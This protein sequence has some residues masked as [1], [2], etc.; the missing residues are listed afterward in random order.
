MPAPFGPITPTIP[1]GRE[2]EGEVLDEKPVA[3]ALLHVLGAHDDVAEARAGRDVDLDRVEPFR[4]LLGEELLV[5]GESRLRLG[6]ARRRAHPHPLELALERPPPGGVPLLLDCQPRFLLLEPRGVV[7]LERE[8]LPAVELEDPAGHVVEEVPIVGHGDHGALVRLEVPLEPRNGLGVEVVRGLV[9]E[10]QVGRGEQEPTE[11]DAAALA[12]GERRHVAVALREPQRVHR[13]VEV[14]LEAPGVGA[15]DAVLHLRLLGQERVEVGVGLGERGG[16]RV[17]AVEQVAQLADAVLDVAAHVLRLVEV[18]LLL[19]E[20]HRRLRIELGDPGRRLLEPRHDPEERRLPRAVRPEHA[21]LRSVQ[22]R[23]RDVREHLPLGAVELVGPVHGVD[24]VGA[25]RRATVA[26]RPGYCDARGTWPR[27]GGHGDPAALAGLAREEPDAALHGRPAR[28]PIAAEREALDRNR[29]DLHPDLGAALVPRG[30]DSAC[31]AA[32]ED[33]HDLVG[34]DCTLGRPATVELVVEEDGVRATRRL[35]RQE[36]ALDRRDV[37]PHADST[38]GLRAPCRDDPRD[39]RIL[40]GTE[41]RHL[42]EP[43]AGGV[44]PEVDAHRACAGAGE[45]ERVGAGPPRLR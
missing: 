20:A 36:L 38:A 18:G 29:G 25:H 41:H 14:L 26:E 19:E 4:L 17:E 23:E 31:R 24:D 11:R 28:E 16:D 35:E 1:S 13:T 33:G 8:A 30:D 40:S 42:E 6:M 45:S 3:E 43:V 39:P 7:A 10:Q 21:D 44:D 27:A 15:V 5:G 22:E 34:D 2:V 12:A 37:A 9:E 32:V